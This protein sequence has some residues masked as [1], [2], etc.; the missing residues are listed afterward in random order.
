MIVVDDEADRQMGN[1]GIIVLPYLV[2]AVCIGNLGTGGVIEFGFALGGGGGERWDDSLACVRPCSIRGRILKGVVM[3]TKMKRTVIV[4]RDYLHY[5]RKYN[6]YEKRHK[7]VP[8]HC[9]PAFQ[10]SEGDRVVIGQCRYVLVMGVVLCAE[11]QWA[12]SVERVRLA[13]REMGV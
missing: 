7:N 2:V 3:S 8:A 12:A 6:R 10:I 13:N 1:V 11:G 5:V 4:R 9:T